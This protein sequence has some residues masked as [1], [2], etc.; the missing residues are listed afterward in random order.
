MKLAELAQRL[1]ATLK[2]DPSVTITGVAS[3]ETAGPGDL[4]FVANPKYAAL[5]RTTRAAAIL[6]DPEFAEITTPTL[7]ITNPY[8]AFAHAIEFFYQSPVYAPGIHP[9]AVISPSAKL[10]TNPH[11][12]A[13]VVIGDHAVIGDNAVLLPHSVIYSHVHAGDNLFLHSHAVVREHCRLGDNV[14]L[15]N[16]VIVGADGFGFAR[17]SDGSWYKILQSGPAILEDNVEIQANSCIDRASIG[18]TRIGRGAKIDNLV[19]VGHGSAIGEDTLLCAQVGLAGSTTVGKNVILAG[20]VGVAGHCTIGDGVI[21]TAQS[22]IPGDVESGKVISGYPAID[23]R[24]WLR[25]VALMNRLPELL[26][27]IKA[28]SKG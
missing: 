17:Q 5:A 4:T 9:T 16:G 20:Q 11:V 1:G 7:R 8:L 10:G 19:Q 24:Q 26:R 14:I 12:G 25:V 2:G 21:A 22:G 6:V 15:Q 3:I 23:N 28:S 27:Q 18:E 13:Y